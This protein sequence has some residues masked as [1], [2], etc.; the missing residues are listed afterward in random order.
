ME[1][2][3]LKEV[4]DTELYRREEESFLKRYG[5]SILKILVLLTLSLLIVTVFTYYL[6]D[7]T[8][9]TREVV[10]VTPVYHSTS[11]EELAPD[12]RIIVKHPLYTYD[13]VY[14]KTVPSLTKAGWIIVGFIRELYDPRSVEFHYILSANS[15]CKLRIQVLDE[16]AYSRVVKGESVEPLISRIIKVPPY[17]QNGT[18]SNFVS[19]D[20]R[21]STVYFIV[22]NIGSSTAKFR[23]DVFSKY[24]AYQYEEVELEHVTLARTVLSILTISSATLALIV[25]WRLRIVERSVF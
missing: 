22:E 2:G 19:E 21:D 9:V 12:A 15:I 17:I 5:K 14:P 3:G 6:P 10:R 25:W 7:K 4:F 20:V 1:S 8:E 11:Y 13:R 23:L 24:K 18:L 16:I